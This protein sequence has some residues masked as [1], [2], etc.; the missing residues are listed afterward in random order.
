MSKDYQSAMLAHY[1]AQYYVSYLRVD[2]CTDTTT[3][4]L[5]ALC[6]EGYFRE[7]R[8]SAECSQCTPGTV[9]IRFGALIAIGFTAIVL[10]YYLQKKAVALS[11][12]FTHTFALLRRLGVIN[13]SYFQVATSLP[14][15]IYIEW[16]TNYV[17]MLDSLSFVNVDI[18]ALLGLKC[19]QVKNFV[20][21]DNDFRMSIVIMTSLPILWGGVYSASGYTTLTEWEFT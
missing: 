19:V 4:P 17:T 5:C 7:S 6:K 16:P 21:F 1:R 10:L 18:V 9:P 13:M 12:E 11:E 3:G 15:L 2:T 20:D 14:R 8:T